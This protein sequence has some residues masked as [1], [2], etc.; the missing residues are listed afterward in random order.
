MAD[1]AGP[2]VFAK[3]HALLFANQPAENT[4]GPDDDQLIA[5]AVEAGADEDAVRQPIEDKVYEQW[6][7]NATDQMSKDGVN[8]TPG[9]FID[10]QL[11]PDPGTAVNAVLQAIE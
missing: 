4:A 10:G 3:Y 1:T 8:G 2:E 11:Q 5:W 9:V 7:E 6:I